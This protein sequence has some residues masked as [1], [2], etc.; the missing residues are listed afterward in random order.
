MDTFK[1]KTA[2][3]IISRITDEILINTDKINDFTTGSITQTLVEAEAT[4]IEQLYY[5][6]Y[7][8]IKHAIDESVLNAFGFV[9]KT[10][11][12]AYGDVIITFNVPTASDMYIPKGTH[13]YCSN[14]NYSQIFVTKEEYFVPA[15]SNAVKVTVYCTEKGTV[16]N[17]PSGVID[18]SNDIGGVC[19]VINP[20]AFATGQD[21]EDLI[22]TQTRF[23]G[24][25]QSLAKGTRQSLTYAVLNV[26]NITGC[27]LYEETY[28]TVLVYCHDANGN[29]SPKLRQQ[30]ADVLEEYRPAGIKVIVLPV[31]KSLV[32]LNILVK[33]SDNRLATNDFSLMLKQELETY[34]D[35]FTVGQ[36]LYKSDLIQ[37]VM[38]SQVLGI[39]DTKV[40]M[41]VTPDVALANDAYVADDT[42]INI[43]GTLVRQEDLIPPD[44][45]LNAS[46]G[47]ILKHY[48]P[49]NNDV[50]TWHDVTAPNLI[51]N[52]GF[53]M[54]YD[55]YTLEHFK[56]SD[57][58]GIDNQNQ[59]NGY[60]SLCITSYDNASGA[61]LYKY[62]QTQPITVKDNEVYS[63]RAYLKAM[64][65]TGNNNG[66][67]L[68][69]LNKVDDTEPVWS[70]SISP[71]IPAN[72]DWY[73]YQLANFVIPANKG[74]NYLALR[75]VIQSYGTLWVAM[76]QL[77][78]STQILPFSL[79]QADLTPNSPIPYSNPVLLDRVYLTAPNE[80]LRPQ[81]VT[82]AFTDKN[83]L[84]D[85]NITHNSVD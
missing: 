58:V 32:N 67:T 71:N 28:G 65:M 76:P 7:E 63:V 40:E 39:T 47:D 55:H 66:L 2:D 29:L 45:T 84:N 46:Y 49:T 38:N 56:A 30:V 57:S 9:R 68:V 79:A 17:V 53:N 77:N 48:E 54:D 80:L 42:P 8:N 75:F 19:D 12:N 11:T 5:L 35:S 85:N 1:F 10:A 81:S 37:Q 31:H 41:S 25:I 13:F 74:I 78:Q 60:N 4:E 21:D 51:L 23:R 64:N 24:M 20:E 52:A 43:N 33:L 16:G 82:I 14:E 69:G 22:T 27:Y 26:P 6:T 34:L 73:S 72:H 36:P 50:A 18:R 61:N 3:T 83:I 59:Y 44:I 70:Y 15:N 62:V